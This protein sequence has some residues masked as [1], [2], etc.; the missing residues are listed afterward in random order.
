MP[1]FKTQQYPN[2]QQYT[3]NQYN[4]YIYGKGS[5]D[6]MSILNAYSKPKPKPKSNYN[7]PRNG[8][9]LIRKKMEASAY[10]GCAKCCG[11][12]GQKTTS[13]TIPQQGRTIAVPR[14]IPFGTI[15]N[16]EGLGPRVAEDTGKA[17]TGDHIDVF[18]NNHQDALNFGRKYVNVSYS[19]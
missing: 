19:V 5:Q 9:Q 1:K 10:C 4:N 2:M 15:V 3:R 13:G 7:T 18:F 16:I 11:K 17:I 14:Y 12:A 8:K 6:L